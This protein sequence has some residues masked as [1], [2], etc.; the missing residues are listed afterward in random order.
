MLVE[1]VVC[2]LPI[3]CITEVDIASKSGLWHWGFMEPEVTNPKLIMK[4]FTEVNETRD[5]LQHSWTFFVTSGVAPS[6]PL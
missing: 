1:G 3:D 4:M 5:C 2:V 6:W